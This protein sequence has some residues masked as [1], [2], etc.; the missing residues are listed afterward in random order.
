KLVEH[1]Q[2]ER[3]AVGARRDGLAGDGEATQPIEGVAIRGYV[4]GDEAILELAGDALRLQLSLDGALVL[5]AGAGALNEVVDVR[6]AAEDGEVRRLLGEGGGRLGPGCV[7]GVESSAAERV[8]LVVFERVALDGD[9]GQP[10]QDRRF[11][12]D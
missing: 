9:E 7:D 5:Q 8:L 2:G 10:I 4:A 3:G 12:D 6:V 1:G 11:L